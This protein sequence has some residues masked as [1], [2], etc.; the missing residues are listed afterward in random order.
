MT[1]KK[2]ALSTA[3]ASA[4]LVAVSAFSNVAI[5]TSAQA[6][7]D[8]SVSV[9]FGTSGFYDRL[10]PYGAWV[11]Y[12]N[13]YVFVPR[14]TG[15]D[16]RPYTLGHWAYTKTY[17]WLWVSTEPFGWAAYHYG[18]WGYARDI[19]WYWVPG[20]RWAPAWVAWSRSDN[21]VAWAPLPPDR[22]RNNDNGVNVSVTIGDVPDYYWQ[23]VPTSAFLSINL[24]GAIIRDRNHVREL[25]QQHQPETIHVE[26][27]I[28]VNNVINV[29]EI[30]KATNKKVPVL[31]EKPVNSPDA[32]GKS[33]PG[34]VAIFNPQVKADDNAKPKQAEPVDKVIADR[35]AKGQTEDLTSTQPQGTGQDQSKP[36]QNNQGQNQQDQGKQ[37][38]SK[39]APATPGSTQDNNAQAPAD[40]KTGKPAANLDN[41][42]PKKPADT[43]PTDVKPADNTAPAPDS[44]SKVDANGKPLNGT[45]VQGKTDSNQKQDNQVP[46]AAQSK[47]PADQ[48]PIGKASKDLTPPQ[49]V[50]PP[51]P[52][53][54]KDKVKPPVDMGS[55]NLNQPGANFRKNKPEPMQQPNGQQQDGQKNVQPQAP[56]PGTPNAAKGKPGAKQN[57]PACDPAKQSCPPAQ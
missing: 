46:A 2:T 43:K 29:N 40:G 52:K 44:Q 9:N 20:R 53:S 45:S 3:A 17:G 41:T 34:S 5:S 47:K 50:E 33:G 6:Q 39:T 1:F 4:M 15:R 18:R 22:D 16:W 27:N 32:V 25:V 57:E 13:D 48:P 42:A 24:S 51:L 8:V 10:Q 28:V 31:A 26:N 19:G 21:E 7:T 11:S 12:Q 38:Q 55:G 36:D 37:D 23:A 30:E 35:K 14:N 56:Q 54:S 49:P